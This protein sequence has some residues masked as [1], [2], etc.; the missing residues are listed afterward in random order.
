MSWPCQDVGEDLDSTL[1]PLFFIRNLHS[2]VQAE[3]KSIMFGDK[4]EVAYNPRFRLY[5]TT[6]I[7]NPHFKPEVCIKTTVVNFAVKERGLQE[8]LLSIVVRME[9]SALEQEK[10]KLV[11]ELAANRRKVEE[12]EDNILSLLQRA[13]GNLLDDEVLIDA[14]QKSKSMSEEVKRAI[15][16]GKRTERKIDEA[17]EAYRPCA[18]RAALC[19]FVMNDLARVDSMYQFSL[20]RYLDLFAESISASRDERLVDHHDI[21]ERIAAL[22]NHHTLAVYRYACMALFER[23]KLLFAFLLCIQILRSEGKIDDASYNFFLRGGQVLDRSLR[24][25]NPCADWLSDAAWDIITELDKLPAFNNLVHSF[26]QNGAEW[27]AWYRSEDPPPEKVPPPGEWQNKRDDFQQLLLLRCLRPDR[28]L[29]AARNFISHHLG[30]QFIESPQLSLLSIHK[31]S[32][33]R[34]PLIFILSPGADPAPQLQD[35]ARKLG[36][37]LEVR[38]MGQGQ[39]EIATQ[40]IK[41]ALAK[42]HWVYLANVHLSMSWLPELEKIVEQISLGKPPVRA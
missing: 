25:P 30:P 42:G 19:F 20:Q 37:T 29:F 38:A 18:V 21:Q 17:R 33:E 15:E 35:L 9:E 28:L 34:T 32:N 14:L 13:G 39:A 40:V 5:I 2:S 12:L 27:L 3:R 6:K 23:H 24:P 26:E 16:D 10:S 41:Q 4:G 31:V 7:Q 22:N 1:D 36:K 11:R 8:Q